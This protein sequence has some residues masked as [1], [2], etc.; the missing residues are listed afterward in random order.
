MVFGLPL[1]TFFWVVIVWLLAI[2]AA[3]VYGLTYKESDT[4]WTIEDVLE[5]KNKRTDQDE[6]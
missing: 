6:Q 2:L 4:W 3:V 5:R 1:T